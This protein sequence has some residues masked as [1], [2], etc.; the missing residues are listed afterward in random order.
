MKFF[1]DGLVKNKLNYIFYEFFIYIILFYQ[2]I[3]S[4]IIPA[5]CRYYPTCSNYGK[6]ALEWHGVWAG[7]WLL[8][9]RIGSCHPLGG[10]GIDFVPLPLASYIYYYLPIPVLASTS[11]AINMPSITK[12]NGLGLGVYRD[13][14]SY[15]ALLNYLM[16][17]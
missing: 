12:C 1:K 7:G 6:Q 10:H 15:V 13:D 8:L 9:K 17:S 11:L 16:R 2:R 5:R 14:I 4:P 3:I